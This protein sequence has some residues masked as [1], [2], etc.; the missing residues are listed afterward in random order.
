MTLEKTIA[1]QLMDIDKRL[2]VLEQVE[3]ELD[4]KYPWRRFERECDFLDRLAGWARP[5]VDRD[6]LA[7]IADQMGD[8]PGNGQLCGCIPPGPS[9]S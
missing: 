5:R 3:T 4:A 9:Q 6:Y 1:A 2:K 8:P 7:N